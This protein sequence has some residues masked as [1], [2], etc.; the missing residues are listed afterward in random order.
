M[1]GHRGCRLGISY[2]EIT[3]MQSKAILEA[4]AQLIEE[5]I[6]VSPEIMV[7]LVGST[8]EFVNQKNIIQAVSRN[9]QKEKK[10]KLDYKIGTMIELPRACLSQIKLQSL[11][12]SFHLER[13]I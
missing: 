1:L 13:T 9:I 3:E 8:Q 7:P 12:I 4:A 10:I 6:I 2:P 11:Q 5:N